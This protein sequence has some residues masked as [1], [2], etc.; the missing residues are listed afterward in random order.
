[1]GFHYSRSYRTQKIE[2][3]GN[4][5]GG[6]AHDFNNILFPIV[7]MSELLLEDLPPESNEREKA[8]EIYKA[9]K[10]GSDL[11]KQILA[12]SRQS[13]QKP[14]PT[15]IQKVLKEVSKL[16]RST[17]PANIEINWDIQED[18]GMVMA[19]PTQLHQIAMNIITNA[20]HAVD[21]GNGKIN[22]QLKEKEFKKHSITKNQIKPGRYAMLSV[23]DNGCGIDSETLEMIFEPYFTTKEQGKGTGLGLAVV[24]GIVKEYGGEIFVTSESGK[25]SSFEVCIPLMKS[26]Y[27]PLTDDLQSLL[28]SGAEKILVVDDEISI[29][30]L[31]GQMLERLGYKVTISIGSHE[32][33]NFFEKSP[34]AFDLI[35]TDMSMPNMTGDQLAYEIRQIRPDIPI[36]IC[37]GFSERIN[38]EKAE[39]IGVNGFLMKP[40]GK[41]DMAQMIRKILDKAK[42]SIS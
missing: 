33:L 1:M 37:T 4:L 32:A 42:N 35:L 19:E 11:V 23:S 16:I 24:H 41:S 7:G 8:E 22:I 6:I 5:A 14:I 25:G 2:S 3:I 13:D 36:I 31:E 26:K 30:K 17:I 15:R 29:A 40:I 34:K 28:P 27:I 12:F 9:G 38:K 10:R 21:S 20:Y 18:C 39:E